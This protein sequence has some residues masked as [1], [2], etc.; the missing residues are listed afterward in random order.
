MKVVV[1]FLFVSFNSITTVLSPFLFKN[2]I[3]V[4]IK[5]KSLR[6]VNEIGLQMIAVLNSILFPVYV[7]IK[8]IF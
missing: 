8:N 2:F 6:K 4:S 5:E 7:K 1:L 3:D